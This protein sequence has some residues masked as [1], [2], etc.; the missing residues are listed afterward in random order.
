MATYFKLEQSAKARFCATV[1]FHI[2]ETNAGTPATLTVLYGVDGTQQTALHQD[3]YEGDHILTLDYLTGNLAA[4]DHVIGV[5][6][7]MVGGA[8][9]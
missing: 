3:Y 4:G 5:A 8:L 1:N 2:T 7:G 9:S 6:F